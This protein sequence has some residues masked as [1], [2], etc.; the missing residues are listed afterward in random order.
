M[1]RVLEFREKPD[2]ATAA[3][4]LADG[5]YLWN[6]GMFLLRADVYL[7]ELGRHA[8]DI[9]RS[10]EAAYAGARPDG[11]FLRLDPAAFR[12]CRSESVD[13]AVMEHTALAKLVELDAPW[14]DLGSFASLLAAGAPVAGSN[15]TAGEV[16]LE[17]V[18]GCYVHSSGRLVAAIG[19]RNQVVVETPDA[20][21]V[22]PCERA[23]EV[24]DLV[25]AL[26]REGRRETVMPARVHRPW[27]WY[28]SI[29]VGPR[30]QAKRIQ[31]DPGASLSLQLHNRRA[32][33]WVV[34]RGNAEITRGEERFRL[35][36]DQSTYISVGTKHRLANPGPEPLEIIEIQTGDYLG[37]D[38]IVR[39][40]D[41][42]GRTQS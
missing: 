40:E 30:F 21:F 37:E 32:E 3:S 2:A 1:S 11:Q 28:E 9:L 31:V 36:E 15:L 14:S 20:V 12:A 19:L 13:Y 5:N 24:K 23:E 35:T 29:V 6:S 8:P 39:F 4:F 33:H 42:Y 7:A 10:A 27:G 22:A 26:D 34:V 41:I 17:D 18:S 38:D 16:R 25:A